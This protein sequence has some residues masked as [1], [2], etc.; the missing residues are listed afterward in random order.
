M[1]AIF[2]VK[3]A[4][5]S[6]IEEVLT[7][8]SDD[9]VSRQSVTIRDG[10]VLGFPDLARIVLIEG[11]EAGVGHAVRRFAFATR[12]TGERAEAVYRAIKSQEDD[13]ASGVG[14]IFG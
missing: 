12:I 6:K 9:L 2:D 7:D 11:S 14:L 4:D 10:D 8:T 3:A 1:Y 13:V 5:R